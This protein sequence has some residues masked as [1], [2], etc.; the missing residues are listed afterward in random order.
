MEFW[1]DESTLQPTIII[2][3]ENISTALGSEFKIYLPQLI[4]KI[5]NVLMQ[6]T[7][8]NRQV[9][10]KLLTTIQKFGS[11]LADY[12]HLF[13]PPI[14]KLFDSTDVPI[15]IRRQALET[16]KRLS[17]VLDFSEFASR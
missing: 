1:N 17:E 2:L 4:P 16:I 12:L 11:T 7:S 9:T 5:L 13:L 8:D 15:K 3:V 6:D 10:E 14:V